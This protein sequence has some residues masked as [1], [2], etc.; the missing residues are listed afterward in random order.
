VRNAAEKREDG[1]E[2]GWSRMRIEQREDGA[3]RG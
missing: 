1:V 2:E 3:E